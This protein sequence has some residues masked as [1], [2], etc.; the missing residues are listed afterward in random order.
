MLLVPGDL[1]W[2]ASRTSGALTGPEPASDDDLDAHVVV[3][4]GCEKGLVVA[5]ETTLFSVHAPP[6]DEARFRRVRALDGEASRVYSLSPHREI[7]V[8]R[9]VGAVALGALLPVTAVMD[10][11]TAPVQILAS[12]VVWVFFPPFV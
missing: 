9:T 11:A 4:S 10:L 5:G 8:G 2:H 1:V 6:R 3:V 7:S 12:L